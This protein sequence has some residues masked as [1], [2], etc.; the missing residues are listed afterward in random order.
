MPSS[1]EGENRRESFPNCIQLKEFSYVAAC[2]GGRG[3]EGDDWHL[4]SDIEIPLQ[5][6]STA[7]VFKAYRVETLAIYILSS[8]EFIQ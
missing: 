8:T 5:G 7:A 6:H 4:K 2:G 3:C 1:R